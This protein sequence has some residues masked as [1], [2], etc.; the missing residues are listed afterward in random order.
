MTDSLHGQIRLEKSDTVASD[1]Q[2][3]RKQWAVRPH[4]LFAIMLHI[5][6]SR[7]TFRTDLTLCDLHEFLC[8]NAT[9]IV[10]RAISKSAVLLVVTVM[11]VPVGCSCWTTSTSTSTRILR[12]TDF[13]GH[14]SLGC[15]GIYR[16]FLLNESSS[17]GVRSLPRTRRRGGCRSLRH[18]LL[19][20]TVSDLS[21]ESRRV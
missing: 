11:S 12:R 7:R 1:S 13:R 19:R 21:S 2:N 9:E 18:H 8:L 15:C 14:A 17:S 16:L 20:L 3:V 10:S 6:E 4:A 5:L